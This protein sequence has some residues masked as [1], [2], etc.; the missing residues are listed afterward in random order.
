MEFEVRAQPEE[1][2]IRAIRHSQY[3]HHLFSEWLT[4]MHTSSEKQQGR[5]SWDHRSVQPVLIIQFKEELVSPSVAQ[6]ADVRVDKAKIDDE[7]IESEIELWN[8]PTICYVI[9]ANPPPFV[10]E[11]YI[12]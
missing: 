5:K 12:R 4:S 1:E 7:D 9:G 3:A 2:D 8:S 10:M 11:G 6:N